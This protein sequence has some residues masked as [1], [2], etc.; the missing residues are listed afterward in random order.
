MG[1]LVNRSSTSDVFFTILTAALNNG[2]SLT[3]TLSSIR[4]QEFG[5]FEHIVVDGGSIDGTLGIL[6]RFEKSYDLKFISEPDQGIADAL[7]KGLKMARGKYI[8]V[9]HADDRLIGPQTLRKV[10][11][12]LKEERYDIHSFPVL[13][14]NP[15]GGT[16]RYAPFPLQW[17]HH[18]KT[19]IPH[20]GAFVH[21]RAYE[22][23]GVYRHAFSIAMDYDFFYRAF[24]AQCSVHRQK[25]YVA[26]MGGSGISNN[27]A[28]LHKRLH[29]EALV[30]RMNERN[31]LWRMAQMVFRIMYV[32]YKTLLCV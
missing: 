2:D 17:W 7:N 14:D 3:S 27:K 28:L 31:A 21:S 19:I 9:L 12:L 6:E 10:H 5:D 26:V 22:K 16:R 13:I 24:K 29:E 11:P 15:C 1:A 20:Q 4:V 8:L 30:Y 25:E 23:V 18:F 32:P